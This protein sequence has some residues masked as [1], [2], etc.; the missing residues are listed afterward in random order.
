MNG[1]LKDLFNRMW[2]VYLI[3]AGILC[4]LGSCN[5]IFSA[6]YILAVDHLAPNYDYAT[7]IGV[8]AVAKREEL[9][10]G[11][12][13]YRKCVETFSG[14]K[15][16]AYHLLGLYLYLAGDKKG[17]IDAINKSIEL[18]P[19]FFWSRYNRGVY[20]FNEMNYSKAIESFN[21]ALSL[22][23]RLSV[24]VIL[25]SKT[26]LQVLCRS[27]AQTT[28][29]NPSVKLIEGY[30][31]TRKYAQISQFCLLNADNPV[32]RQPLPMNYF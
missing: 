13:Y 20:Y 19:V 18:V 1:I 15:G 2:L 6:T 3:T 30:N 16:H 25:N 23:T 31:K 7:T 5:N 21:E 9:E 26:Y 11:I 32:C 24:M 10:T 29:D 8:N 12:F 22:D 14:E 28:L 17:A 4:L 27:S